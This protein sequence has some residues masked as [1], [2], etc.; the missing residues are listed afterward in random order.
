MNVKLRTM[1]LTFGM[2]GIGLSVW[3]ITIP[4]SKIRF[5]LDDATLGLILFISGAG[6]LLIMPFA[7]LAIARWGSRTVLITAG[8]LLGLMLPV[9]TTIPTALGFTAL[10]FLYGIFFGTLDVAINA[11][12]AVIERLSGRLQMSGFHACYSLGSLGVAI[13]CSLLLRL[14]FSYAT[15]AL[16][17]SAVILLILTQTPNLLPKSQDSRREGPRLALPNRA[18]LTLGLCCFVCFMTEA[19]ATDWS[20]IFL[21]FSRNMPLATAA[22][23]YAAYAVATAA[24]R[25]LGDATASRLGI[26]TVMRL[27]TAL[28][29]AGFALTLACPSPLIDILGFA[30]IGLGTGNTAPLVLSAAARV[31]GIPAIVGLGYAG[32]L[33]GPVVIG[34]IANHASLGTAL[35]LNAALLAATFFAA[36]AVAA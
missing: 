9:L 30:L 15:S 28:A 6:G 34:L 25:L 10:L 32:F 19:T 35:A 18:T 7:G 16:L 5:H 22:L 13:A 14:H 26:A 29:V 33:V 8:L 17:D 20:T 1:R 12:G 24:A 36:E 23:G 2:A 31:K 27:G 4:F 3:A 11:Q 21:R